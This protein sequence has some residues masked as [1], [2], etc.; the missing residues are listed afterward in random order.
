[1]SDIE[2]TDGDSGGYEETPL[3][4]YGQRFVQNAPEE[5]RAYAE[6]YV[7][8]WD[9][10]YAKAKAQWESEISEYRQ[11][12]D[13]QEL[14]VGK[15]LYSM[16][17][18]QPEA[19]QERINKYFADRGIAIPPQ[20]QAVEEDG[21]PYDTRFKSVEQRLEQMQRA[22]YEQ[23]QAQSEKQQ[24]DEFKAQLAEARKAH[25]DF[26]E[27]TVIGLIAAGSASSIDAA[28]QHYRALE[29]RILQSKGRGTAP[30]L[31]GSNGTPP[32]GGKK[33][34]FSKAS[35]KE[36]NAYIAESLKGD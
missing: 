14:N 9:Q 1:M 27:Q 26:D 2:T 16:L 4:D 19:F 28:V 18:N 24:I 10:G 12:G 5:E 20:Q 17:V 8:Q 32:R 35:D 34:D 30:N 29:Q 13:P 33:L 31:L 11:L 36:I 3:S 7:K 21:D 23:H 22:Q 6:K 25:G 15:Q